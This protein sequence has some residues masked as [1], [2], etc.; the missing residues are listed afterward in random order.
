[1]GLAT[2]AARGDARK[3]TQAHGVPQAVRGSAGHNCFSA[4]SSHCFTL[5]VP[6]ASLPSTAI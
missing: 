3:V 1:M 5:S 6:T 2:S 4:L